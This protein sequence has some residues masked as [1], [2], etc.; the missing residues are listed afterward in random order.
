MNTRGVN[1]KKIYMFFSLLIVTVLLCL[2]GMFFY[3]VFTNWDFVFNSLIENTGIL[4][5]V[6]LAMLTYF[7][8]ERSKRREREQ[9]ERD[10]QKK[11]AMQVYQN[12]LNN[13]FYIMRD[14]DFSPTNQHVLES[15]RILQSQLPLFVPDSVLEQLSLMQEKA[16]KLY[17]HQ[18]KS[19]GGFLK[20]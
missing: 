12:Y 3:S 11:D 1:M 13:H 19:E 6:F 10:K 16:R 7:L 8:N 14:K 17:Y 20:I 2:M 4:G 5:S 15:R 9:Q 18:M